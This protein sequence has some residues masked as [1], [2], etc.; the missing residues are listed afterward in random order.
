MYLQTN[1][2]WK[3]MRGKNR[4]NLTFL[5]F[6]ALPSPSQALSQS[7]SFKGKPNRIV[8]CTVCSFLRYNKL[9]C[10]HVGRNKVKI[11]PFLNNVNL[12]LYK[13]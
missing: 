5:G 10:V 12:I 11:K 6:M 1:S 3:I 8:K 13:T 4:K 9:V 7:C 2:C